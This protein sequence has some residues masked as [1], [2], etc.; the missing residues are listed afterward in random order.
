MVL[1]RP[2]APCAD[3]AKRFRPH[4]SFIR[5]PRFAT[6]GSASTPRSAHARSL[7][8]VELDDYSYVVNDSEIAYTT[9]GKFC[10]IAA[11]T[12]INP[13]NHPMQR[14]TQSHFTYRSSAYFPGEPDEAGFFAWRRAQSGARSAT[15][16]GSATARSSCPAAASAPA[17]WWPRAPSSPRTCRPTR[18]S[19]A[20][21]R[22]SSGSGFRT[23]IA[24]RLQA[25]GWWDWSHDRLRAGA[26]GFS[27]ASDR[28]VP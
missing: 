27:R 23:T 21:R 8:E 11:M 20:I 24:D 6:A 7:T 5:R 1:P 4:R 10:S 15:T 25:L 19:P 3:A 13:G 26:A 18:S 16:S 14:A 28:S 9:I 22:G 12:R 17:P 2:T